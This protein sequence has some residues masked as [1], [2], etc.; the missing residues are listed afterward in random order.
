M[1]SLEKINKNIDISDLKIGDFY[2][3]EISEYYSVEDVTW[4]ARF[5][6]IDGDQIVSDE[7]CFIEPNGVTPSYISGLGNMV[8]IDDVVSIRRDRNMVK[9]Y[10][11][12]V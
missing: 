2:V 10:F 7:T 9:K 6:G 5:M 1:R 8:S 3:F 12:S 11:P 4:V